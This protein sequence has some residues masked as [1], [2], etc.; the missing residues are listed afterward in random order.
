MDGIGEGGER[1]ENEMD[2]T[3]DAKFI[4]VYFPRDGFGL[5]RNKP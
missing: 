4:K 2:C 5:A 1:V 3:L